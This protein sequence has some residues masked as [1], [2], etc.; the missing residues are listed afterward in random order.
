MARPYR[1]PKHLIVVPRSADKC[2]NVS[3]VFYDSDGGPSF[4]LRAW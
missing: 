2:A 4:W 3:R 1:Y